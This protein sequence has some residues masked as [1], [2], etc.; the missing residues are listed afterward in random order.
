MKMPDW[1]KPSLYGAVAGAVVLAA[2]GFMWGG[3]TTSGGAAD[4]AKK[5][6]LVAVTAAL[7]PYCVERSTTDPN[8]V[9]VLAEFAAAGTG[10]SQ[11]GVVEKAGWATPLGA[12]KPNA[13]LANACQLALVAAKKPA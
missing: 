6:S 8:S 10:F 2:V 13:D 1:L 12:E 7:L 9:A 4:L 3:W 5:Q 11:R